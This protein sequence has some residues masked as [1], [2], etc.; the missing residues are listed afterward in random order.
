MNQDTPNHRTM[1]YADHKELA[2]HM[3]E[4]HDYARHERF[5]RRCERI[6]IAV[7]AAGVTAIWIAVLIGMARAADVGQIPPNTSPAV[8]EWFRGVQS[9]SGMLCCDIADGHLTDYEVRSDGYWVP[10]EGKMYPVPPQAVV[11]DSKNP[12]VTG[13]VWYR[14]DHQYSNDERLQVTGIYIR[15]FVPGGGS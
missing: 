3:R 7:L 8:R 10:F 15:C 9:Q 13:I 4:F 11:K 2:R 5:E 12:F 14:V 6:K 1:S